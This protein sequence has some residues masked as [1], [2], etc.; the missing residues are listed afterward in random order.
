[1]K[2]DLFEGKLVKLVPMDV[3]KDIST[4]EKWDRNSEFKRLLDD[5]PA[6]QICASLAKDM[7]ESHPHHA[8]L[9]TIH[10]VVDDV[11]IGFID[12]AGFDWAAGSGWVGIGIGE[13]DYWGKG[14]GSEAMQLLLRYAF[15]GLNL[16]RVNLNVFAFN[17][18]AIRSYEKCG[19]KYE[20]TQR[21]TIYKEDQRWDV[22]DMGILRPDWEALQTS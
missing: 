1:M 11:A 8:A 5:A 18:R 22:I 2:P 14:Y 20:G 6:M 13:A 7:F 10:T 16:H 3:D 15:R 12:L 17:T 4:W 9:F 19:F 21:E